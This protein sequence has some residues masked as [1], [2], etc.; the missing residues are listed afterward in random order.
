MT[1]QASNVTTAGNV[2]Y[3]SSGNTVVTFLSICN[4][5]LTTPVTANVYVVPSGQSVGNS[6][7]TIS[8]LVVANVD[9]YQYYAGN[10]KLILS[11]GDFIHIDCTANTVTA[12]TSYTSA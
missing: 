2:V 10:E 6:Y 9:T 1:I 4:Y 5:D 3:T 11:N 12:V 7:I 8:N